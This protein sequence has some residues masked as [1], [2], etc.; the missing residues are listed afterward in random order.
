MKKML[1]C[2][3]AILAGAGSVPAA[4]A[5]DAGM[6]AAPD[7]GDGEK[8]SSL[9]L[10]VVTPAPMKSTVDPL[11]HQVCAQPPSSCRSNSDCT[12]SGCCSDW[13]VCITAQDT[14]S[15]IRSPRSLRRFRPLPPRR[16][17]L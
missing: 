9:E 17:F 8:N 16:I 12:C 11:L 10:S 4:S 5:G 2:G 7:K 13:C 15:P 14:N 6:L 3:F 1:L